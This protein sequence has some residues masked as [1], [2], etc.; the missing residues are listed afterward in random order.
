M[1]V[2]GRDPDDLS[3]MLVIEADRTMHLRSDAA[4][5]IAEVSKQASDAWVVVVV[6]V[7]VVPC[8]D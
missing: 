8:K 6:V 4:I 5:R 7:V 1:E 3:S 2:C